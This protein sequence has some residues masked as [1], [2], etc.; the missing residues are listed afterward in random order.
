LKFEQTHEQREIA[1]DR[2][3]LT[4]DMQHHGCGLPRVDRCIVWTVPAP[5]TT[6]R[7]LGV[8]LV[9][10]SP[11]RR[12]PLYF[13]PHDPA[14]VPAAERREQIGGQREESE[15]LARISTGWRT[16]YAVPRYTVPQLDD[17]EVA[18]QCVTRM[19]DAATRLSTLG[20]DLLVVPP[21]RAAALVPHHS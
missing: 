12:P 21:L 16:E 9:R 19:A 14:G 13:T 18:L 6:R 8:N 15:N 3:P 1:R 17:V 20:D 4:N 5:G 7:S 10:V 11:G 2:L